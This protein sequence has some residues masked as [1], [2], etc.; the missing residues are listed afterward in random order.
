VCSPAKCERERA[1]Q[2]TKQQ[3]QQQQQ[4]SSGG[5]KERRPH[6]TRKERGQMWFTAQ[7]LPALEPLFHCTMLTATDDPDVTMLVLLPVQQRLQC[8]LT[9]LSD[10][11]RVHRVR[12]ENLSI[13]STRLSG[14][15]PPSRSIV[16]G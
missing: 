14:S 16:Q 5:K 12:V 15:F 7:A 9:I 3:Q 8:L 4:Q 10:S 11:E 1:G 6:R 2:Q 13:Q